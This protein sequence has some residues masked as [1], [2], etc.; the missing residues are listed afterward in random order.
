MGDFK[1]ALEW[2]TFSSITK[3]TSVSEGNFWTLYLKGID[4]RNVFRYFLVD[5]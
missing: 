3:K 2:P 1:Q 5:R 4:Q